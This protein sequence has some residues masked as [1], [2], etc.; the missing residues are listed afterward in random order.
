MNMTN[1]RVIAIVG[2][3]AILLVAAGG[4]Y[5]FFGRNTGSSG[6]TDNGGAFPSNYYQPVSA[7]NSG[8]PASS[9]TSGGPADTVPVK[10]LGGGELR[11]NPF[12]PSEAA[13]YPMLTYSLLPEERAGAAYD[14]LY[15][16]DGSFGV[17]LL[18]EPL[19]QSRLDAQ[20]DLLQRL[21]ISQDQACQLIYRVTVAPWVNAVYAGQNLGFT[22]CISSVRL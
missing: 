22:F 20:S 12:L 18:A 3:V 21:G 13:A 16:P 11:V 2:V 5:F 6:Q 14:L 10:T 17:V 4:L 8:Q 9:T 1:S 7:N 19:G 15:Y